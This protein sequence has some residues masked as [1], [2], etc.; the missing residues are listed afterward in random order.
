MF[1]FQLFLNQLF[2]LINFFLCFLD[3]HIFLTDDG[4]FFTDDGIFV[5]D[6]GI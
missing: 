2:E 4:I 1:F 5:T 3:N 6:D